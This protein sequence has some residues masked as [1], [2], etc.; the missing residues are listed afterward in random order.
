MYK[1]LK[2]EL[3]EIVQNL[4]IGDGI[5][6]EYNPDYTVDR[7]MGYVC[8]ITDSCLILTPVRKPEFILARLSNWMEQSNCRYKT[9]EN[10]RVV[11]PVKK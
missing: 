2:P 1:G 6:V 4:K 5:I 9:L 8:A 7:M 10:V 3:D 11:D